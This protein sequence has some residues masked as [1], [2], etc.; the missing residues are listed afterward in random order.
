MRGGLTY[1][2][3]NLQPAQQSVLVKVIS[4][5]YF[6]LHKLCGD[7]RHWDYLYL[8]ISV[9]LGCHKSFKLS[10]CIRCSARPYFIRPWSRWS[11]LSWMRASRKENRPFSHRINFDSSWTAASGLGS[12][13][14]FPPFKEREREAIFTGLSQTHPSLSLRGMWGGLH[15]AGSNI[16]GFTCCCAVSLQACGVN[17]H[18]DIITD[19]II[20]VIVVLAEPVPEPHWGRELNHWVS[21]VRGEHVVAQQE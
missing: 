2:R 4:K 7:F 16:K 18:T 1:R 14:L 3:F 5:L 11:R 10:I 19:A 12:P 6:L 17:M 9:L 15:M 8:Y 21:T 20:N 13:S